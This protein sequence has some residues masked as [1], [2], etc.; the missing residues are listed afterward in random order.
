MR[1]CVGA[2]YVIGDRNRRSRVVYRLS[3]AQGLTHPLCRRSSACIMMTARL[4]ATSD[5]DNRTVSY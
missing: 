4:C 3:L 1:M 5:Q 2:V